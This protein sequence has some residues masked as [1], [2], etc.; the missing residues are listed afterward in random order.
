M[1]QTRR[2][3][4]KI[5]SGR[6]KIRKNRLSFF[7]FFAY[8]CTTFRN[9]TKVRNTKISKIY[10]R[11]KKFCSECLFLYR[12]DVDDGRKMQVHTF[13]SKRSG[14]SPRGTN[15]NTN[16]I[17][18]INPFRSKIRPYING[19]RNNRVWYSV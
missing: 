4:D 15:S 8:K 2:Y 11:K 16:S 10:P 1:V 5:S 9:I 14:P 7:G 17:D 13:W 6:F 3:L 12:N 18:S 19:F